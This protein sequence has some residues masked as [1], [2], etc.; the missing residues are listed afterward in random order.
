MPNHNP[1]AIL[2]DIYL[3][4]L[5]NYLNSKMT[6]LHADKEKHIFSLFLLNKDM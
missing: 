4:A 1:N 2:L 3:I 5:I 6:G